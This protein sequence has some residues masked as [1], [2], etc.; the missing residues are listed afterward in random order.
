MQVSCLGQEAVQDG[1]NQVALHAVRLDHHKGGLLQQA[2]ALTDGRGTRSRRRRRRLGDRQGVTCSGADRPSMLLQLLRRPLPAVCHPPAALCWPRPLMIALPEPFPTASTAASHWQ[3]RQP[4]ARAQR[5][6]AATSHGMVMPVAAALS[7]PS[8]FWR[9]GSCDERTDRLV[10]KGTGA[11]ASAP[12]GRSPRHIRGMHGLLVGLSSLHRTLVDRIGPSAIRIA[13]PG[14]A[15]SLPG[16][17]TSH[18]APHSRSQSRGEN[19]QTQQ[20]QPQR[21][22]QPPL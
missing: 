21:R 10:C 9:L 11:G 17:P 1:R 4:L 18:P 3:G 15:Q 14:P 2:K 7:L 19:P 6:A 22:W 16:A 12:L 20:W 13:C 5:Q 8:P